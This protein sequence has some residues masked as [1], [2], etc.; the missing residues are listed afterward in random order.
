[1]EVALGH[2]LFIFTSF[3]GKGEKVCEEYRF[4]RGNNGRLMTGTKY[5]S[6]NSSSLGKL[7]HS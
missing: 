6:E 5:S 4:G 3:S 1:L 7:S 2:A